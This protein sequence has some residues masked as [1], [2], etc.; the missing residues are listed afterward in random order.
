MAAMG[1]PPEVMRATALVLSLIVSG[2]AVWRFGR[3]GYLSWSLLW[4]FLLG[5]VP[6][7]LF[8]ASW[9]PPRGIYNILAGMALVAAA[10]RLAFDWGRG[11]DDVA[12]RTLPRVAAVLLGALLGWFKG[13]TGIGA[14]YLSPALIIFGWAGA[15]QAGATTAAFVFVTS[16]A[17]IAGDLPNLRSLPPVFPLW[18]AAV[19]LGGLVGSELS[20]RHFHRLAFR[21]VLAAVLVIAAWSLLAS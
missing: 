16:A 5:S 9:D 15:R 11:D 17:A 6:L 19:F 13:V 18:M 4:P 21:R 3:A 12:T 8:G 1:S 2:T 14:I 10:T 20:V 7:A